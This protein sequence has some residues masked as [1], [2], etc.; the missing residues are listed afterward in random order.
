MSITAQAAIGTPSLRQ[1]SPEGLAEPLIRWPQSEE[2][3]S[4]WG[5]GAL[6]GAAIGTGV[7][8]IAYEVGSRH[9]YCDP[10]D[11]TAT[12]RCAGYGARIYSARVEL[13]LGGAVAGALLGAFIGSRGSSQ[14][15]APLPR[16]GVST[17][18]GWALSLSIPSGGR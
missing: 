1:F 5:K 7:G 16:L 13:M 17:K 11:N 10:A 9:S 18:G 15:W 6:I 4:G 8:L 3:D 12:Y 2:A 14:E